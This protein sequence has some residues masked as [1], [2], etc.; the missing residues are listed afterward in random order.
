MVST[1]QASQKGNF[2]TCAGKSRKVSCKH[3]IEKLIFL[4]FVNLSTIFCPRL[5]IKQGQQSKSQ[6]YVISASLAF[7]A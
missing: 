2:D 4:N 5:Q 6:K 3:S 7:S 1:Q